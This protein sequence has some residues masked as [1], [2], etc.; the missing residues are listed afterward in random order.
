MAATSSGRSA[1]AISAAATKDGG[2]DAEEFRK[3]AALDQVKMIEI[4]LSQGAKPSHG[5]IL[6]AAKVSEE[7]SRIRGIPM[8]EDCISP[9]AHTQFA[10]PK[11]LLE[12]VARLRDLS[13]GKPVGFKLCVGVKSEFMSICKAM[14]ETGITPD[15]ITVDGAEGGTGA[16][17][18]EFTDYMGLPI[19]EGLAFVH[20]CL[21]GVNLRNRMHLIASGKVTNGFDMVTKLSL[22]AD[23]CNAARAMM[24]AVGCI[25]AL[26]CNDNTCPTGVATQ[27]RN[28]A[29]ALDVPTKS[30]G[31]KNYHNAT[32]E[33]F[34]GPV[35]RD[36]DRASRPAGPG[37]YLPPGRE[38]DDEDLFG[39]LSLSAAGRAAGR[40]GQCRLCQGLGQGERGIVLTRRCIA[41]AGR[42]RFRHGGDGITSACA[43]GCA[44]VPV[45]PGL[46]VPAG[47][48][49]RGLPARRWGGGWLGYL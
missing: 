25:Q 36:G 41:V 12:F 8:G 45:V 9:P 37:P 3:K 1:P 17:P 11:A 28:R 33:S 27:D 16:A 20:S 42:C 5:G 34:P 44:T 23:M 6:P 26:R 15:F 40:R 29:R 49:R 19:N 35:R 32:V 4:K 30:V 10:T 43:A 13:G 38:R 21:V 24:F 18:V 48:G 7:I 31:V 14:L 2:F 39:D 46:P 22:G 47:A